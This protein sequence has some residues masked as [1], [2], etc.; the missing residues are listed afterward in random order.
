MKFTH[1]PP[2]VR[3]IVGRMRDRYKKDLYGAAQYATDKATTRAATHIRARIQRVRLGRLAGAV[4]NTSS[5]RK[6]QTPDSPYGA[7]Y[8]RGGDESRAGQALEAYGTGVTIRARKGNWLAFATNAVPR[9][10]GRKM[11]KDF[12]GRRV[13][14][15]RYID[16]GLATSIGTLY[17]KPINREL[18][19]FVLRNVTLHPKTHRAKPAGPRAPRTRVAA[20][21]VVAFVLIRVT[22]RAKRFD[23]N[24]IVRSYANQVPDLIAEYLD[25]LHESPIIG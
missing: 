10:F 1:R 4:G 25:R 14:L 11:E 8:A 23:K 18:A 12:A 21:E 13:T 7:I 15:G 20:A 6:R 9:S 5:L 3:S 19:Y 22:T 2:P 17:F 24:R 16:G